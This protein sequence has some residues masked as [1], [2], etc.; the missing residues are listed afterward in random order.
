MC[1]FLRFVDTICQ[2]GMRSHETPGLKVNQVRRY[3]QSHSVITNPK[4]SLMMV[5]EFST[6][7]PPAAVAHGVVVLGRERVLHGSSSRA[8]ASFKSKYSINMRHN[9]GETSRY[10]RVRKTTR[11]RI[12]MLW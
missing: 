4:K 3:K 7:S 8:S 6:Y 2:R 9:N 5:A 11:F 12:W 1:V 10:I